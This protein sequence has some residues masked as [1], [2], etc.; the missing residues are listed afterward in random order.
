MKHEKIAGDEKRRGR[1]GSGMKGLEHQHRN[2]TSSWGTLFFQLG[3]ANHLK[4]QS[5]YGTQDQC[6]SF[7]CVSGKLYYLKIV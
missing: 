3:S 1:R 7:E 4:T 6:F 5:P 2:K